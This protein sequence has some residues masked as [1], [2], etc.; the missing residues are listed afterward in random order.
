MTELQQTEF[1]ILKEFVAVCEQLRLCYYLVC[2]SCLGAVKYNGFIPWD[3]DIDV[4][5]PR[6]DYRVFCQKAPSMLPESISSNR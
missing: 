5:M 4:A 3:D 6:E 2:G 1:E